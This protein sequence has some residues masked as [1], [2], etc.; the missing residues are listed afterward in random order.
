LEQM[1]ESFTFTGSLRL[2]FCSPLVTHTTK[3]KT[4]PKVS[5]RAL[6]VRGPGN[7]E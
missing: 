5:Y 1:I 7:S 4:L 3:I 2:V 6:P